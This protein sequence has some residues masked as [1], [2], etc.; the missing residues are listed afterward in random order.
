M[1]SNSFLQLIT[2]ALCLLTAAPSR[3]EP[4]NEVEAKTWAQEKGRHL[5]NVFSE[6]DLNKRY[7][8]LDEMFLNDIDLD[9]ISKFVLGKYW[10]QLD[11]KGKADYQKLFKRYALS[12]YKSFPLEFDTSKIDYSINRV[13]IERD[14]AVVIANIFFQLG[15]KPEDKQNILVEFRMNKKDS[16]IRIID[17]KIGESSLILSYRSRFYEMIANNDEDLGWFMEDLQ[18]ITESTERQNQLKVQ[19]QEFM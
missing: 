8:E 17:L 2:F 13:R 9:Y 14:N 7:A 11:E 16:R 1:K 10:R 15:N 18:T 4:I 19:E 12:V 5:L 3:A 6:T